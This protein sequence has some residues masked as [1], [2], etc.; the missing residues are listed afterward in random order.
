[1]T[2]KLYRINET[3]TGSHFVTISPEAVKA[4]G[5]KMGDYVYWK[6]ENGVVSL[7]AVKLP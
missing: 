6:V 2:T 5:A 7:K 3:S 4:L 1:M